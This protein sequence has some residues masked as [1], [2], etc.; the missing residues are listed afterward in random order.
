LFDNQPT[1]PQRGVPMLASPE[2]NEF[3]DPMGQGESYMGPPNLQ[4]AGN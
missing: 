2:E 1:H 3:Y 4:N